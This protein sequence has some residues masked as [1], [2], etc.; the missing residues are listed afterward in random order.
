MAEKKFCSDCKEEITSCDEWFKKKIGFLSRKKQSKL[1]SYVDRTI[2]FS[3]I[4]EEKYEKIFKL[5]KDGLTFPE[6]TE[7]LGEKNYK[8]L[9]GLFKGY[10]KPFG[11][12]KYN[13]MIER[14]GK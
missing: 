3:F 10:R 6:I 12:E 8:T 7:S 14:Y 9:H 4:D 2:K 1:I 13:Q 11:K 5:R